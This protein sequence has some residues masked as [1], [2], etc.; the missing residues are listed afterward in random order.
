MSDRV[1]CETKHLR[2]VDRDGWF[3]VDRP[4][5]SGVVIIVAV[6]DDRRLLLVEQLRPAVG[7]KVL[8]LPA[9][10]AGD[11]AA[12]RHEKLEAAA[13]REL[14]EETGWTAERLVEVG[15]CATAPG[16]ANE[17]V[18]FF[19]ATGLTQ[20]GKGGGVDQE[21]IEVHAVPLAEVPAFAAARLAQ[22]T[23]TG[24]LVYAG[25]YFAQLSAE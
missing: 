18:T 5:A 1:L 9:G 8:E 7:A 4:H 19:R 15:S 2:L 25:L 24:I 14:L 13:R 3:F 16:L 21:E 23:L 22:G 11:D 6:T 20:V 12:F 17:V 10:L